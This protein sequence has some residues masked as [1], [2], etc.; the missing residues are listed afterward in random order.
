MLSGDLLGALTTIEAALVGSIVAIGQPTLDAIIERR[1]RYLAVRQALQVAV[2]QAIVS[3][4]GGAGEAID[5]V[6]RAFIV[7]GQDLVDAVLSLNPGNIASAL[8]NGTT[9]VL[10][11]FADGTQSVVDGIVTAQ[12]TLATA[13]AAQPA[14][15]AATA[16]SAKVSGAQVTDVPDLSRKSGMVAVDP[17][18]DTADIDTAAASLATT[19]EE[20]K[21]VPTEKQTP[22]VD[23]DDGE[24]AAKDDASAVTDKP[25][26]PGTKTPKRDTEKK[27]SDSPKRE[28]AKADNDSQSEGAKQKK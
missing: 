14:P 15:A 27:R 28:T 9:L 21:A 16:L 6:L 20:K 25:D 3:V 17:P 19:S 5:G 22:K 12:Q 2:P 7:A 26:H 11:S 24:S 8:V 23:A 13:L 18:A 4:V 10:G 1:Q